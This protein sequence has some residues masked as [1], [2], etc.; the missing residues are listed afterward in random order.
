FRFLFAMISAFPEGAMTNPESSLARRKRARKTF[1]NVLKA[2][3]Q[4][5]L[6]YRP[7]PRSRTAGELAWLIAA[8][9][10][11]LLPLIERGSVEW[12]ELHPPKKIEEIVAVYEGNAS[13]V[14]ALIARTDDKAWE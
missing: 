12:M 7:H 11:A 3:P 2:V 4:G 6:D 10:A 1:I 14:D 8:E 13:A 9:D 5:R